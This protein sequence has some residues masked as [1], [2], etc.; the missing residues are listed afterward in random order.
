MNDAIISESAKQQLKDLGYP[1]RE[2]TFYGPWR[3]AWRCKNCG[4]L[5][6]GG[7]I[8][9][10]C[11]E[12]AEEDVFERIIGR[13]VEGFATLFPGDPPTKVCALWEIKR[14]CDLPKGEAR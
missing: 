11:I 14:V 12:C 2:K 3:Y 6:H 13:F 9:T 4:C 8:P 10:L 7:A 5:F 1:K